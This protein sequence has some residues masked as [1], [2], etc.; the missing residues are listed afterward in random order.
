MDTEMIGGPQDGLVL[1]VQPHMRE[2][3]FP[4]VLDPGFISQFRAAHL[5]LSK[6]EMPV[7]VY[8][9]GEGEKFYYEGEHAG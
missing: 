4:V 9:R 1:R 3:R 5:D 8:R 7:A 6:L 2:L